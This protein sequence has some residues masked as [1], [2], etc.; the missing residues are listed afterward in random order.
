MLI[1]RTVEKFLISASVDYLRVESAGRPLLVLT[2][3]N[4][5][6]IYDYFDQNPRASLHQV[7]HHL[8]LKRHS[9]HKIR[10]NSFVFID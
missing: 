4:V 9:I 8:S 6:T 2:S 7:G 3:E 1:I 10:R 5:L